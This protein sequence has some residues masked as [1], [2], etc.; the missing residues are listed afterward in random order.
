MRVLVGPSGGGPA[1]AVE[2]A[3]ARTLAG[4]QGSVTPLFDAGVRNL[5][6][7]LTAAEVALIRGALRD[8][9]V[10]GTEAPRIGAP[11]GYVCRGVALVAGSDAVGPES[12]GGGG[13]GPTRVVAVTDHAN[14]TWR[15]PLTGPN[16]DRI[17]PRF[18]SMTGIYRPEAVLERL[19]ATGGMIVTPG[20]VAGV[21]DPG[22]LRSFDAEMAEASGCVAA[23]SGLVPVVIVAAHMGLAVAAAVVTAGYE[24]EET[25]SGRP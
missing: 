13:M 5:A 4:P 11:V 3:V 15:S 18:P 19:G 25:D 20:V 12:T 9:A 10:A 24:E 17:G 1:G 14:L 16:D 8:G 7:Q 22:H 21:D 6:R 23:S 2:M